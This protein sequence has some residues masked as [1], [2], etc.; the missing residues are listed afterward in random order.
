MPTV[1]GKIEIEAPAAGLFSLSQDYSL[2]RCWD[3]FVKEMRFLDGANEAAKGVRVWVRA[4]TG[5]TM[6]VEFTS[7]HPPR[8]VAMR[9]Q[10]GPRFLSQFAG[11]WLFRSL[12]ENRTEVCFRYFFTSRWRLL[13]L[14][15]DPVI[16]FVFQRD[17]HARLRGLKR[18]AE[19]DHL[20]ERLGQSCT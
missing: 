20:L 18:G 7:F 15:F 8:S 16:R 13:R 2:R 5:L 9:M 4:W 10:N 12:A 11:T 17:I 3:P 1:E 19:K 14:F 6:E